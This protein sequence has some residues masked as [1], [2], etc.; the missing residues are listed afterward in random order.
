MNRCALITLVVLAVL[1]AA[2]VR[3]LTTAKS[4]EGRAN[5]LS[6]PTVKVVDM[7]GRTVEIPAEVRK[8]ACLD[9]LCY[10]KL[11]MLG[12]SDRAVMMYFTD[13]P[14]MPVADPNLERIPKIEGEPNLEDL[15]ESGADVAFFAYDAKRTAKKLAS[16]DVPGVVSQPQG[17]RA[18]DIAGFVEETRRSVLLYGEVMGGEALLQAKAWCDYFDARVRYVT[19]R[20][21]PI[22]EN[23]RPRVFYLRGPTSNHTQGVSGDTFWYGELAGGDMVVKNDTLAVKGP[24]SMEKIIEWNPDFVL[25]GRRYPVDMVLKDSRWSNTNAVKTGGVQPCPS[26]V[27][28]WDGGLEGVL[29]MEWLAKKLHPDLFEDLDLVAEVKDFYLRFYRCALS[30]EQAGKLVAGLGPDGV[31]RRLYNN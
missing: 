6:K 9:V 17:K 29:L 3:L 13:A 15:L 26:G 14:W 4:G 27:F 25:V 2:P 16:I 5:A 1:L 24:V 20:T 30:D 12:V 19:A 28:Y 8:A 31:R 7:A 11:L 21:G 18:R 10:Q 22:P 23:R